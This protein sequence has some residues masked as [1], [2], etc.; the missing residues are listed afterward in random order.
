[1][2]A[3]FHFDQDE[4]NCEYLLVLQKKKLHN[5][6]RFFLSSN[7]PHRNHKIFDLD[8]NRFLCLTSSYILVQWTF[9]ST[10]TYEHIF[11]MC[12]LHSQTYEFQWVQSHLDTVAWHRAFDTHTDRTAVLLKCVAYEHDEDHS[13]FIR[14]RS[15]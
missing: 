12:P 14:V 4:M 15:I 9:S 6:F 7:F 10:H 8:H 13:K 3:T 1:M 5:F 11:C 2:P